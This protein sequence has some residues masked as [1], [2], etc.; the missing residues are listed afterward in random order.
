[1]NKDNNKFEFGELLTINEEGY[2]FAKAIGTTYSLD[3]KA[4]IA[5][6][7]AFRFSGALDAESM[8]DPF[9]LFLSLKD[10][11]D[12]IDVFCQLGGINANT[13]SHRLY[14]FLE[15]T[16]HEILIPEGKAF[17]PKVWVVRYEHD[18]LPA[19]YKVI[20]LTRNMTFDSCWDM[21]V[22]MEGL[23]NPNPSKV[24]GKTNKPLTDFI[25]YLY[26]TC[27]LDIPQQFLNEL[28]SVKFRPSGDDEHYHLEFFPLGIPGSKIM[29]DL[30]TKG[31]YD[32]DEIVA[33]S[34]FISDGIIKI[35]KSSTNKLTL[36]SRLDTF[37]KLDLSVLK[38]VRCFRINDQI[39]EGSSK[40]EVE[41]GTSSNELNMIA[42]GE[43]QLAD[44]KMP[45]D[46]HA[47]AFLFKHGATYDLYIGSANAT[48]N[49]H[50]GNIE[51]MV[52]LQGERRNS[53]QL[54]IDSFF[55]E[56]EDFIIPYVP[57]PLSEVPPADD[58]EKELD[59]QW[60]WMLSLLSSLKCEAVKKN[61]HDYDLIIDPAIF[62]VLK[63]GT[64][65]SI[66]PFHLQVDKAKSIHS[67]IGDLTFSDIDPA[68]LSCFFIVELT[69][70]RDKEISKAA[71][72]KLPVSNMPENREEYVVRSLFNNKKDFFRL[73][74]MLLSEDLVDAILGS[75]E[76]DES[77][78]PGTSWSAFTGVDTPLFERLM[79]AASRDKKKLIDIDRI[80]SL[81]EKDEV[82]DYIV[83]DA[84]IIGFLN[85]WK[86]FKM[87]LENQP[88]NV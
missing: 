4:L 51:F 18:S 3:L 82:G 73:L 41:S 55:S 31:N 76:D 63:E 36:I 53:A 27:K 13:K 81:F 34:P 5:V 20:V 40:L 30:F 19:R 66:R 12:K 10:T 7:V 59:E 35:L 78:L 46:L 84:D 42:E 11:A 32:C 17:H 58:L 28:M 49:A 85:M 6:P 74:R 86:S 37:K 79:K 1:M 44:W 88:A 22:M 26:E 71:V 68:D 87:I 57:D 2:K 50:H 62:P 67:G 65:I 80:V 9:Q 72:F 8:K 47:K 61:E 24:D 16:I 25:K 48:H 77:T 38:D 33:V 52:M 45:N 69:L 15:R 23:V 70:M 21:T 14:R 83:S 75:I 39:V 29:I 64:R 56:S 54:F 43:N 60:R